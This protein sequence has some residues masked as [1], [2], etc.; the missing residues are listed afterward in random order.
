[1]YHLIQ[2]RGDFMTAKDKAAFLENKLFSSLDI[3]R[4]KDEIEFVS[5]KKGEAI[6]AENSFRRCLVLIIRGKASVIKTGLD[7]KKTIINSLSVGDVFGMASLFYEQEEYPSEI[8]AE[9][10]LRLAVLS[11]ETVEKSILENPDFAKAYITL[12]SEKIHFL[13]KKLSAFSESEASEKLFRWI[14]STAGEKDEIELPCSISRLSSMLGIGRAS[15]YRA[16]EALEEK[17]KIIKNGKKIV[18][19]KP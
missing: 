12:L 8:V 17:K 11:K 19:L 4:I 9:A 16:F 1:M 2:E 7:G 15:V 14:L 18:I 3:N 6:M 13:N 5:A 10:S